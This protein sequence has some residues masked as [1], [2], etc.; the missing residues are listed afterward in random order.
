VPHAR[1][2]ASAVDNDGPGQVF[3][4]CQGKNGKDSLDR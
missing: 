1:S 4:V 3:V 2:L